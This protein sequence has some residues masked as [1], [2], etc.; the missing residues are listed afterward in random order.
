MSWKSAEFYSNGD[1]SGK[2]LQ[3]SQRW[4]LVQVLNILTLTLDVN[5]LRPNQ[6][7]SPLL[8]DTDN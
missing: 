1:L 7:P 2:V 4:K 3:W 6:Q 8:P 5:Q